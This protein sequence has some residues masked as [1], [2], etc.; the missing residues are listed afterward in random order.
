VENEKNEN[1]KLLSQV[2]PHHCYPVAGRQ[3][4]GPL[5]SKDHK[6]FRQTLKDLVRKLNHS[7]TALIEV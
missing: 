7:Q 5:P 1:R 3:G 6:P 4:R 2:N